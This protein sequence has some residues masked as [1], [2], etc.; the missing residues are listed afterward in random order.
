MQPL[1]TYD[2][3]LNIFVVVIM[4]LLIVANLKNWGASPLND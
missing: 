1:T 3:V 4:P 2:L